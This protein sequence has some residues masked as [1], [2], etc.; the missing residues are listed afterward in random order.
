MQVARELPPHVSTGRRAHH[1]RP[2]QL[3]T[4]HYARNR[5]EPTQLREWGQFEPG[6]QFSI[7]P[8]NARALGAT[9]HGY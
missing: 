3:S 2:W 5:D 6:S 4:T 8:V 7:G 9:L 1:A